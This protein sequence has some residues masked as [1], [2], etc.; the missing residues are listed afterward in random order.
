MNKHTCE[1]PERLQVFD[2]AEYRP[3][4]V[5]EKV[6]AN[7]END[8]DA[9]A[10]RDRLRLVAAGGD[11][12]VAWVLQVC[13]S[14]YAFIRRNTAPVRGKHLDPKPVCVSNAALIN[15]VPVI[16]IAR[17]FQQAKGR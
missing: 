2:L 16:Y 6:W 3:D 8:E 9:Q 5:L 10:Y 4:E 12:T 17:Q 1:C 15:V 13:L 7:F 14:L 11:G